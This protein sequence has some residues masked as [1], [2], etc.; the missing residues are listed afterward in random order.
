M[1]EKIIQELLEKVTNIEASS[2]LVALLED[3][4][5]ENAFKEAVCEEEGYFPNMPCIWDSS[6]YGV[7]E[8]GVKILSLRSA[9]VQSSLYSR[10]LDEEA[11]VWDD[12]EQEL[13]LYIPDREC[14]TVAFKGD[15]WLYAKKLKFE[16]VIE[17]LDLNIYDVYKEILSKI[18]GK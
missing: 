9:H 1:N 6:S 15:R 8:N 13:F 18:K 11:L 2:I 17:N 5:L 3:E 14:P 10:Y 7:T 16:A 4:R 12:A